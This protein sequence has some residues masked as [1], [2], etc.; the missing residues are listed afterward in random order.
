MRDCLYVFSQRIQFLT[1]QDGSIRARTETTHH[2]SACVDYCPVFTYFNKSKQLCEGIS[3]LLI[4]SRILWVWIRCIACNHR[5][6]VF[7]ARTKGR[8]T[9]FSSSPCSG[10]A[11]L[12]DTGA[13]GTAAP[14]HAAVSKE[15][16][17]NVVLFAEVCSVVP[18]SEAWKSDTPKSDQ[19]SQSLKSIVKLS[20][21][22]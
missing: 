6:T 5:S 7:P 1:V 13:C 14:I 3:R 21:D 10:L 11:E 20:I 2:I 22:S 18:A 17:T 8:R 16:S 9:S 15:T 19:A 12:L 4:A